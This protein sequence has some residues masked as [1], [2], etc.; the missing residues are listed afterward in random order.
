VPGRVAGLSEVKAPHRAGD[1]LFNTWPIIPPGDASAYHNLVRE[2]SGQIDNSTS[3]GGGHSG[4]QQEQSKHL[5]EDQ[6]Q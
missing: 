3:L 2:R 6:V 4:Y 1:F 5:P